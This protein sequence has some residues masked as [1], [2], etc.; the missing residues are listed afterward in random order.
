MLLNKDYNS[1][2]NQ[3]RYKNESNLGDV[4]NEDFKLSESREF[5]NDSK[6]K[7]LL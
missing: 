1:L 5:K 4:S 2:I 6:N 7:S 3:A